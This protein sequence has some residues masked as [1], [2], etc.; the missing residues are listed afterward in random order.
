MPLWIII[1]GT[2]QRPPKS[3]LFPLSHTHTH[4]VLW[5]KNYTCLTHSLVSC[6]DQMG[7]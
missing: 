6:E 5:E 1:R 2:P 7:R 3:E 4:L